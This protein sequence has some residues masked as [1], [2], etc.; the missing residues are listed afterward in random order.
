V[1]LP[2]IDSLACERPVTVTRLSIL[3]EIRSDISFA[4]KAPGHKVRYLNE[5]HDQVV[6]VTA[7]KMQQMSTMPRDRGRHPEQPRELSSG[8]F[9]VSTRQHLSA[10]RAIR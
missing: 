2:W 1:T 9:N 5:V 6:N 4:I 8:K 7:I 3:P 10:Q